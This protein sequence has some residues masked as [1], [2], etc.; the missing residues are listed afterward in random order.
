M[1]K[2]RD[3]I[4]ENLKEYDIL[5]Q[6]SRFEGFGLTIIEGLGA[7]LPVVTSNIEGPTEILQGGKY[8]FL[9]NNGSVEDLANRIQEIYVL[10]RRNKIEEFVEKNYSY[11]IK[12]FSI[13]DTTTKYQKYYSIN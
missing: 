8:G 7:K 2:S 9:F 11:A 6:P 13:Q 10:Y 1:K 5:L 4:Y 12:N 3:W